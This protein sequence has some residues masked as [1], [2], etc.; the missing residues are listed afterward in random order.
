MAFSPGTGISCMDE[1]SLSELLVTLRDGYE[2]ERDV[3]WAACYSQFRDLVWTRVFYVI[4]TIPWLPE[5]R[6]VVEEITSDVFVG[7][8][9]A[10]RA[11]RDNGKGEQWLKQVAVRTALRAR[12]RITGDWKRR[13]PSALSASLD[14]PG[15]IYSSFDHHA[16]D[17]VDALDAIKRDEL[18]ELE[19]RIDVMRS[20]ADPRQ[21]R[22]ATF[23]DLYREGFGF[24]E[25]GQR[26]GLT[27][28]TARN[29][30]VEIRRQLATPPAE[31]RLHG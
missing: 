30:L 6:E 15:R 21:Q 3:A 25:I 8:P 26:M 27:E 24:A 2:H 31:V 1:R 4:R 11:Y 18:L 19:R 17:I 5:P 28:G 13:D 22:W 23:L 16:N 29:W 7:L 9:T 14:R 20:S 12:E 10:V